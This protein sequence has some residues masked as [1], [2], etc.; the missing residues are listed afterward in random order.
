MSYYRVF[1]FIITLDISPQFAVN[2]KWR[3]AGVC[4]VLC[5]QHWFRKVV[6]SI[7]MP[8]IG[9]RSTI[10]YWKILHPEGHRKYVG[11]CDCPSDITL[12]NCAG[13]SKAEDHWVREF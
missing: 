13:Y 12:P 7:E 3:Y 4:I 8:G 11:K 5:S 2:K 10:H 1:R 9:T 6:V